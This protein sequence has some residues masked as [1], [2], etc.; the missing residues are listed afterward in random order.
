MEYYSEVKMKIL[1]CF[2]G[3]TLDRIQNLCGLH[4]IMLCTYIL[5]YVLCLFPLNPYRV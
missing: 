2:Y 3:T 4:N 1:I 5:C